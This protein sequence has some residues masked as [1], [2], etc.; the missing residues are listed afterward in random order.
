ML[1]VGNG[2]DRTC[3]LKST[4]EL[5]LGTFYNAEKY[6]EYFDKYI[7]DSNHRESISNTLSDIVETFRT[8]YFDTELTNNFWFLVLS[9]YKNMKT[10]TIN[11][12]DV[13]SVIRKF[14][15]D[16]D[17]FGFDVT[18]NHIYQIV[19][20]ESDFMIPDDRDSEKSYLCYSILLLLRVKYPEV[21]KAE[22][23]RS[24]F[25]PIKN[26][27]T[28]AD[29]KLQYYQMVKRELSM[30]ENKF[31][32]FLQS[33]VDNE[34]DY[35][36]NASVLMT[37]IIGNHDK[38]NLINFNYTEP[39]ILSIK[40]NNIERMVHVHGS[41]ADDNL[42][43]GIDSSGVEVTDFKYTLTKTYRQLP[44]HGVTQTLSLL[45]DSVKRIY[46]FGH[47]LN[48]QDYSYFQAIFDRYGIYQSDIV[49]IFNYYIY[50]S[51]KKNQITTEQFNAVIKLID[52]YSKTFDNKGH[53]DNLFQ[54]LLLEERLI[55]R[56]INFDKGNTK[57]KSD[58]LDDV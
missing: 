51:K 42:I 33:L 17:R 37:K 4:F 54:K 44:M 53:A 10:Q 38:T 49:L 11:W 16:D 8:E 58:S 31:K 48:E 3:N 52:R 21:L 56:A 34:S 45:P 20:R 6:S 39:K 24:I 47:S 18:C 22:F 13:E 43:I 32:S 19:K 27:I 35:D 5:F 50:D 30:F 36:K 41:L 7:Y 14:M 1:I 23:D 12:C 55:I 28:L 26:G 15:M 40:N 57:V 9:F 46:F 25:E 29:F 2:F